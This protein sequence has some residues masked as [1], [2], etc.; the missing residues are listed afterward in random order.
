MNGGL[1]TDTITVIAHRKQQSEVY[2]KANSNTDISSEMIR[3]VNLK[4]MRTDL[5]PEAKP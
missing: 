5:F 4:K 3:N 2:R 1:H